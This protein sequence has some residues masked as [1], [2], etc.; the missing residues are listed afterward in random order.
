MGC[1]YNRILFVYKFVPFLRLQPPFKLMEASIFQRVTTVGQ[2]GWTGHLDGRAT[3]IGGP[4][5]W[6]SLLG[7]ANH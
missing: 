3:G 5:E 6:A 2:L 7:W 1:L 4:T